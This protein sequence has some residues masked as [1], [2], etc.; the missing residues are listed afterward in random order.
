ML[1][2]LIVEDEPLLAST[3]KAL[4][5]LN[6]GYAVTGVAEDAEAAVNSAKAHRPHLALVDL[7]LAN[8][9]S[10]FAVAAKLREM[11]VFS[12]F[13]TG[14]GL[15]I[16]VP[17]LAIGCLAKPFDEA[18]LVQTLREAD[19]VVRGRER[20]VRV[21]NLPEQLQLYRG[22]ATAAAAEDSSA[23][24]TGRTSRMARLARLFRSPLSFRSAVD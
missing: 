6:P 24:L 7:Q 14:G 13:I 3:L 4:I 17:D 10:G 15:R 16:P 22:G 19:D 11:E 23:W 2:I 21:R 5:E 9:T 8:E 20:L 1:K 12:L 18:A